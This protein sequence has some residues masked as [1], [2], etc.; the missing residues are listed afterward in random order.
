MI[1]VNTTSGDIRSAQMR[2]ILAR[3]DAQD[4]ALVA[5]TQENVDLKAAA[6]EGGK[7]NAD[8]VALLRTEFEAQTAVTAAQFKAHV[9]AKPLRLPA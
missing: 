4:A 3:L 9:A 5:V 6:A 2:T 8:A 7:T 1:S